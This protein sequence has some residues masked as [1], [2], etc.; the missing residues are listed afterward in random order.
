MNSLA[1]TRHP[2][3]E[4]HKNDDSV[5]LNYLGELDRSPTRQVREEGRCCKRVI[6]TP[7]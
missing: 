7:F 1:V 2:C 5:R 4:V 6:M 3:A